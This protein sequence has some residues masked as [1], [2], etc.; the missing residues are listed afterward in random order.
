M[1]FMLVYLKVFFKTISFRIQ[2][3][4]HGT[5]HHP[6]T[7][8]HFNPASHDFFGKGA[9]IVGFCSTSRLRRSGDVKKA[10]GLDFP[11]RLHT[12]VG[13]RFPHVPRNFPG[14]VCWVPTG[15]Q[16]FPFQGLGIAGLPGLVNVCITME[17]HHF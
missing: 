15:G 14:D 11:G 7:Y 17:N 16:L 13:C 12:A 1:I 6:M 8:A 4:T 10:V 3:A 9:K 2:I 5:H